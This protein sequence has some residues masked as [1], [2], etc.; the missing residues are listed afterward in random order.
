MHEMS[1]CRNLLGIVVG[2]AEQHKVDRVLEVNVE[3]GALRGIVPDYLRYYF[4]LLKKDT[5]ADGA[6]L[7]IDSVPGEAECD[8]CETRF[9]LDDGNVTCPNCA[10]KHIRI[11]AGRELRVKTIR[12]E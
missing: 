12:V 8:D 10:S 7:N 3:L 5:V 11:V 4:D 6:T 9:T 1:I 2:H